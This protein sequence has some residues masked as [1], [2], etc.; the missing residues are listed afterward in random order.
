MK[1]RLGLDVGTNSLGWSVL[2]LDE[3]T[4]KPHSIE[5]AGVRIFS[6]G[7]N[8][9]NNTTLKAE[10]RAARSARRRR[11]RFVQRRKYL[12]KELIHHGLFP[13]DEAERKSLQILN[14]LE[15]RALAI[16]QKLPLYHIGRALFHLNQRRGFKSNRKDRS[17]ESRGVVADSTRLVFEEMN[18]IGPKFSDEEYKSL[19]RDEKRSVRQKEAKDRLNAIDILRSRKELTYGTFLWKRQQQGLSTRSRPDSSGKL[20]EIYPTREL[21]I[22]EFEKIW[23]KQNSYYPELLTDELKSHF[24]QIIYWQ[25]PLRPQPLGKCMYFPNE[26]R[27]FR[28]MPSFQ[29]YRIFQEV[30]N[31]QWG[32][33]HGARKVIED[34]T[35]RDYVVDLLQ[36]PSTKN[37]RVT[38]NKIRN[39]LIKREVM[40]RFSLFNLESENRKFLDGNQTSKIM[41]HEDRIGTQ[42]HSWSTKKQDRLVEIILNDELDDESVCE[43]LMQEFDLSE[44]SARN[45]SSAQLVEGTANLSL[46]AARELTELMKREMLI[47]SDA[48]IE[49]AQRIDGFK[50]PYTHSKDQ[51]LLP[52]LPYY[53]KA[54][55]GHII[56]GTGLESDEQARIGMVSNPTVHIAMNQI[57]RVV[58]ELIARFGHP[59]SIAIELAR[60]LPEGQ[61]GR[62]KIARGQNQYRKEN[63]EYNKKLKE[64]FGS[65]T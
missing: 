60:D 2:Q 18:L 22:D 32:T 55:R 46:K 20:Y 53:G 45:C 42:W 38:F 35:D 59:Y 52:N 14:P 61:Q 40:E 4:K 19:K 37:A 43:K 54:V 12:I 51:Q 62:A 58:N 31:I 49:A 50:N 56:P 34:R 24:K 64:D 6:D 30:N 48:V 63:D 23:E 1:Y 5:S 11:D 9:K 25:R 27:T 41:E 8:R 57:R 3:N 7:R 13:A 26:D 16:K 39:G 33:I 47:Q 65:K 29:N 36:R 17:Q 21:Y 44:F 28:A 10:R 15:L